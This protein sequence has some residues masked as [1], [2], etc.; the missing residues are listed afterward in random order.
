MI[1][2]ERLSVTVFRISGYSI[3]PIAHADIKLPPHKRLVVTTNDKGMNW[4]ENHL[5]IKGKEYEI[6]EGKK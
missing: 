1:K 4:V 3:K 2:Y 6:K 5:E